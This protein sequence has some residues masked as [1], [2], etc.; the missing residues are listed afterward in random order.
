MSTTS[1][2]GIHLEVREIPSSEFQAST[3]GSLVGSDTYTPPCL[4]SVRAA[5]ADVSRV[6]MVPEAIK[7]LPPQALAECAHGTHGTRQEALGGAGEARPRPRHAACRSR[8]RQEL[9]DRDGGN[10]IRATSPVAEADVIGLFGGP[11]S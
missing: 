9:S 6:E 8:G 3:W 1:Q 4:N 11:Q 5:E 2:Q 10:S 7:A